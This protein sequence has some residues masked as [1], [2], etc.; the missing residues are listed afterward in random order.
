MADVRWCGPP[1]LMGVLNA[2]RVKRECK[3]ENHRYGEIILGRGSLFRAGFDD[4]AGDFGNHLPLALL[5]II[6]QIDQMASFTSFG[7]LHNETGGIGLQGVCNGLQRLLRIAALAS[8]QHGEVTGGHLY[9]GG[10][11]FQCQV[12]MLAPLIRI[13]VRLNSRFLPDFAFLAMWPFKNAALLPTI[14]RG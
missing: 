10:E 14:A 2:I 8:F 6:T 1:L 12:P 11:L 5:G 3:Q 7:F 9:A 4:G 13:K